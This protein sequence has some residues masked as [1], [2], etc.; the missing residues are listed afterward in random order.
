LHT[1][2]TIIHT[3]ASTGWGGQEIRIFT[4][5]K[6]MRQRGHRMILCAP[7]RS[8]IYRRCLDAGFETHLLDDRK[9][10]YPI[11]LAA[12]YRLFRKVRPDA[13]NMHSSR[14]GWMAG[15]AARAAKVPVILRSRHIE[16]DYPNRLLSRIPFH[17]LPHHVLTTSQTITDRLV[18]E[19]GLDP[20]RISCVSTGVDLDVFRPDMTGTLHEELK[21]TPDIP[22]V[23]I[24]SVLRYGKGH[25]FFLDAADKLVKSGRK[26][27]F[28]IAG[29]GPALEGIRT[30]IVQLK[31]E[32]HVTLLGH[33]DDV[34]NILAS[35]QIIVLS[36]TAREGIPQ[37]VLQAFAMEKPVVGSAVGGISE[38]VQD[39]VT[40]CLVPPMDSQALADKIALLLDDPALGKK[41]GQAAR[42]G[43][44]NSHSLQAM[45]DRVEAV[46][47]RYH[48]MGLVHFGH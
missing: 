33:R 42:P 41:M 2:F 38:V 40:G 35:L 43:V 46:I 36:S 13:V 28:I 27:H 17:Y 20:D 10:A 11:A 45:C 9:W 37:C 31:L 14:D 18:A 44:E 24:V 21:L 26:A 39:R 25:R 47:R 30:Q 3:E 12:L 1:Q 15:M 7:A 32:K 48:E 22:L 4:E 16:V 5:M 34:P 19:L 23:G 29:D 8:Q 6:A